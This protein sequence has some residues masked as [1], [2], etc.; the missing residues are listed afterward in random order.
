MKKFKKLLTVV[1]AS[2]MFTSCLV[3]DEAP[4]NREDVTQGP[5]TVSFTQ[6]GQFLS[7][8]TDGA[9]YNFSIP[10]QL[11]GPTLMEQSQDVSLTV[12]PD[13]SSTAVEGVHYTMDNM[14]TTLTRSGNYNSSLGITMITDGIMA[15]LDEN[16]ILILNIVDA[17]GNN[18][19]VPGGSTGSITLTFVYQCFA[20]LS[21]TY[22]V[23]NDFCNP[24]FTATIASNGEGAWVISSADGGFLHQCTSNTTLL[25]EGTIVELCGEILPTGNL[26]FG[27]AG[28]YGIGD[29]LSGT[30]DAVSGT[31]EMQHR[32]VFFNGGPYEWN[33]L[34]VRQ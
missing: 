14:S 7:A 17:S 20:D 26:D 13:P 4:L 30:W 24:V 32:D 25:N 27:T 33:S 21:G 11:V 1:C 22:T 29:I 8:V 6:P 3:D 18:V 28:G 2:L 5:N 19:V 23:T 16:P 34:Y 15:P 10:V 31:L 12:S 9:E